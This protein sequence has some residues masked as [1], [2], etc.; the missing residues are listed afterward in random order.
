VGADYG[1]GSN[2]VVVGVTQDG[3]LVTV[4]A[5]RQ[6]IGGM[7]HEFLD[8]S[9]KPVTHPTKMVSQKGRTLGID[10]EQAKAIAHERRRARRGQVFKPDLA[11]TAKAAQGIPLKK[12]ESTK[13]ALARMQAYKDDVDDR[14]QVDI[15]KAKDLKELET[16]ERT[17]GF[18]E[19]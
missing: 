17:H 10:L 3:E 5:I 14:T 15:D 9:A 8:S 1:V 6:D 16:I 13:E 7:T 12:G 19:G 2:N 18:I 11:V 4:K